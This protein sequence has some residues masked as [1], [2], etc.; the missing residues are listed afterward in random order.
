M[1]LSKM[2]LAAGLALALPLSLLQAPERPSAAEP[3]SGLH[4]I[5]FASGAIDPA[6]D[7]A[8][9]DP[10][11]HNLVLVQFDR[12]GIPGI[13][14]RIARSG[15]RLVQPLAPVSYLVWADAAETRAIRRTDGI[16]FAG[17]LPRETRIS[18]TVDASTTELR[19]TFIGRPA[20]VG[21][22][23]AQVSVRDFTSSV[24]T[25]AVLPGGVERAVEL[26][27]DPRAYSIADA[28]R[29]NALRDELSNAVVAGLSDK[30]GAP[31]PGYA[32]FLE[33]IGATGKGVVVGHVDSGVD[34]N[35]PEFGD[36]I[37][38]CF[39]YTAGGGL[40][41]AGNTDDVIG[42]GTHT[43]GIIM[44]DGSTGLGDAGGFAYG[45]GMAPGAEAV[46]QNAIGT[47]TT[48]DAWAKGYTS[49]Y[50]D[51]YKAGALVSANSW[52]PSGS[53]KGYD[54]DTREFDA[55]VRDV[56]AKKD[57][58]QAYALVFSIMNGSGG[59]S[60]QGTPDEGKNIIRVGGSGN[61]NGPGHDDLCTC[62][63]HGPALDGRLLPDLVAP[64]QN[65]M[66]TRATQGT[67]CGLSG[68]AREL[69]PSP[70]HAPC[71]GTSMASPHVSGGYAVFTEWYRKRFEGTP[72]PALVK[73]AFV[74]GAVDLSKSGGVDA[75]G[76][77]LTPI[78]NNQQGWGR[79]NLGQTI[80]SWQRGVVHIDQSVIFDDSREHAEIS[81]KPVDPSKPMKATLVW[82]DALG[83]GKGGKI[84]AWVNDLDLIVS[85]GGRTYLGNVF[86]GGWSVAGGKAD[87]M[88]NIENV[89]LQKPDSATFTIEVRAANIIGDGLPNRGDK[90]DQDFALI[91][92]NAR[93]G[94]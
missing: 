92:T 84:P 13:V 3:R 37:K 25:V 34:M 71:T 91:V 12:I 9:T 28:A 21:L 55:M 67:L 83:H 35:H 69:P 57:G 86:K 85:G 11:G 90:T 29:E 59:R 22:D 23:A 19:V 32:A 78:P 7:L 73:G 52:G 4:V 47:P 18:E 64:G 31:R 77:A 53:P 17:V 27:E 62:S 1:R 80:S 66:S 30:D 2:C 74:N 10:V 26:S 65:V 58:D 79:F 14:E 6:V 60:T 54:A 88:N 75:D 44:G 42:H 16:R 45:L 63:A 39:D 93:R 43:L 94:R 81:V 38:A 89:Y 82:T 33:K 40:C 8:A 41:T 49:A 70:L 61:R 50:L 15:A 56:D 87:R 5:P 68:S 76:V 20:A 36:R 72:S 46:V 24:G 51:A 48:E